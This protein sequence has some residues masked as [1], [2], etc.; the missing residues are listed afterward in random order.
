ML[1]QRAA[2]GVHRLEHRSAAGVGVVRDRQ[3]VA[4]PAGVE[5][6]VLELGEEPFQVRLLVV[7][8][9]QRLHVGV[10]E[11]DVAM[12]VVA[13][14][15]VGPFVCRE[16]GEAARRG[17]VV[18][19]LGGV[20][21]VLPDERRLRLAIHRVGI[22]DAETHRV[23]ALDRELKRDDDE[24]QRGVDAGGRA[25]ELVAQRLAVGIVVAREA[26]VQA[27][28]DLAEPLRVIGDRGEVERPAQLRE[29]RRQVGRVVGWQADLR[30]FR[31]HVGVARRRPDTDERGVAGEARVD[32][33]L[34]E[35]RR[36][37]RIVARAVRARFRARP[38]LR[39]QVGPRDG[40]G[41]AAEENGSERR[42]RVSDDH[43]VSFDL[44]SSRFRN[45]PLLAR[46]RARAQDAVH[47]LEQLAGGREPRR[48]A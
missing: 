47:E 2:V 8:R 15:V 19:L 43:G 39:R 37:Q 13:A 21:L 30:A 17:P 9:R 36:P 31:E 7:A 42:S 20:E 11:D 44:S 48:A 25:R 26:G 14:E 34:P 41:H 29:A 1:R 45:R 22:A 3:E 46:R 40:H 10:P 38:V 4:A 16:R 28:A 18:E 27:G 33:R 24:R 5:T 35:E 32:V 6:L 12:Q 23:G